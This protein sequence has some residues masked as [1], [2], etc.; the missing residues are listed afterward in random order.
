MWSLNWG[1][2]TDRIVIGTCPMTPEDLRR[3]LS[4]AGISGVL[5]LQHDECLAYWGMDYEMMY[6]SGT[7]LGLAMQRCP[8]RNFDVSDMRRCLPEAISMLSNMLDCGYR[9]Y[10]HCTAGMGRATVVVLGNFTLVK[11]CSAGDAFRLILEGRPGSVFINNQPS[12]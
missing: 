7:D 3:I 11:R 2:I 8:I 9:V 6:R 5:S 10:M 1:L 4:E 12:P